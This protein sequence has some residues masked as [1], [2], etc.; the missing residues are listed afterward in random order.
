MQ[1]TSTTTPKEVT[2][3]LYSYPYT[4]SLAKL[5]KECPMTPTEVPEGVTIQ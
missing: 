3:P 4:D 1:L 5:L 2:R